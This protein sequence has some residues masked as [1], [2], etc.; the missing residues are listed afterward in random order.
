MAWRALRDGA[1]EERLVEWKRMSEERSASRGA[2]STGMRSIRRA[3]TRSR[4]G[5]PK[6]GN[7][8]WRS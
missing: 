3:A 7:M 2:S 1:T 5:P 6:L 8:R 4:D